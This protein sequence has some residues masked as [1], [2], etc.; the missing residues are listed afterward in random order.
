M[1]GAAAVPRGSIWAT[2]GRSMLRRAAEPL[3]ES[4]VRWTALRCAYR[5]LVVAP[6]PMPEMMKKTR[7]KRSKREEKEDLFIHTATR[8]HG[9]R[10]QSSGCTAWPEL[11]GY[12]H[13]H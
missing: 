4:E 8:D 3:R 1:T 13:C 2:A 10:R 12:A 5:F 7:I 11:P 9:R 6:R